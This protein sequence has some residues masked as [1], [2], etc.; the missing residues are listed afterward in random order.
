M[1]SKYELRFSETDGRWLEAV[2]NI[3]QGETII[4]LPLVGMTEPDMFSLEIEPGFHIDCSQSPA[5]AIQHSCQPNAAVKR[6]KIVAWKCINQGESITLDYRRTEN[7]LAAPF[8]CH[9]G[10]CPEG[11]RIE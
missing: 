9:C 3:H 4:G 5:G 10:H 7:K 11:T 2:E 6:F 1:V 8:T